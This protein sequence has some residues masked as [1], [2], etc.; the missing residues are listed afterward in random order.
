MI[1]PTGHGRI[2]AI[3]GWRDPWVRYHLPDADL[4][5]LG[6]WVE[7]IVSGASGSW[8]TKDVSHR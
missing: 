2:T 7:E 3:P 4:V 6:G 1:T 5:A 8:S